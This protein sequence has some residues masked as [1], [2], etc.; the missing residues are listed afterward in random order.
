MSVGPMGS[1]GS[2]A[3]SQLAQGQGPEVHKAQQDSADQARQV[4]LSQ[5]AARAEGVGQTEEDEQAGD[6]D[7]DGRRPWEVG[8]GRDEAAPPDQDDDAR[9]PALKSKDPTGQRGRNLDLSG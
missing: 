7:A 5:Q 2:A 6:R 9:P 3:G 4:K 8:K 1:L